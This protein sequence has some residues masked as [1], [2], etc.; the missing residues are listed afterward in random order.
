MGG[1]L[2]RE[3]Q[4]LKREWCVCVCG[5]WGIDQ[6]TLDYLEQLKET[7]AYRIDPVKVL[8]IWLLCLNFFLIVFPR[9]CPQKCRDWRIWFHL[10]WIWLQQLWKIRNC[11]IMFRDDACSLWSSKTSFRGQFLFSTNYQD[12]VLLSNHEVSFFANEN[13]LLLYLINCSSFCL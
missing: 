13:F 7:V 1:K 8:N 9:F 4:L 3:F 6:T 12:S 2:V 5:G 10:S 11:F